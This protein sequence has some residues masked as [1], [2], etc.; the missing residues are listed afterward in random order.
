MTAFGSRRPVV[1][2]DGKAFVCEARESLN[3]PSPKLTIV[4]MSDGPVVTLNAPTA[5]RSR[6]IRWTAD[7]KG[8]IFIDSKNRVDNLWI[9]PI[10]GS[11]ARQLTN[12]ESDRIF[13]FDVTRD[14][15]AFAMARG[16]EDSDVVMVS[17]FR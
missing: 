8:L 6:T 3:D 9:Q 12:F 13:R 15:S 7:G 17:D 5:V 14:G 16:S 1:A 10:D 11:P 2:P 4:S